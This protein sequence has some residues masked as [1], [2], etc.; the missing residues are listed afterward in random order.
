MTISDAR[1][2]CPVPVHRST[3]YRLLGR[4]EREGEQEFV[5]RRHGHSTKFQG[6]VLTV[7]LDYCQ[8]HASVASR[9]VQHLVAEG[10]GLCVSVSQRE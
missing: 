1:R 8:H 2:R 6:E 10:L 7:V 5:E 4:V 3:V 9:E